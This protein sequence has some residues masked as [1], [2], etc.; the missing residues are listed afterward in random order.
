M[1]LLAI[2]ICPV[3]AVDG[4]ANSTS[5]MTNV[6]EKSE[7]EYE[8]IKSTEKEIE[9]NFGSKAYQ[10]DGSDKN[11]YL[12]EGGNENA[13]NSLATKQNTAQG[14]VI[15][16]SNV[17][18]AQYDLGILSEEEKSKKNPLELRQF[19]SFETKSGKVFHLIIDHNKAENNVRMLTEVSE[20]DLLN[21][22]E[23]NAEVA[24]VL[25]EEGAE[26]K[27][28][29][30]KDQNEKSIASGVEDAESIPVEAKDNTSLMII[31]AVSLIAGVAGWYFKIHKPKQIRAYDEE[32]DEA[33]YIDDEEFVEDEEIN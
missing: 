23:E 4:S 28:S 15:E 1:L 7:E 31:I 2:T 18:G 9:S 16:S 5:K 20:Q 3:Y 8:V 30:A 17:Q 11:N 24:L 21:L 10:I 29:E 13:I 12:V 32:V 26:N 6:T 27:T 33:D 19:I 14:S 22:I 25:S